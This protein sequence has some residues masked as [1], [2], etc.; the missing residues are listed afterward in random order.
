VVGGWR[1]LLMAV[2]LMRLAGPRTFDT[3]RRYLDG[4][5]VVTA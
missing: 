5:V 4:L 1:T 3:Y 2:A